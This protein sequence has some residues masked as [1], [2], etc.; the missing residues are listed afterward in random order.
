[1][2]KRTPRQQRQATARML[3]KKLPA[4]PKVKPGPT[5]I[6]QAEL[7]RIMRDLER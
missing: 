7:S 1:M 5:A 6:T 3:A 4:N 2:G